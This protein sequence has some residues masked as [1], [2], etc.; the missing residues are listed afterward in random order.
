VIPPRRF[1]LPS[2]KVW[3]NV[4]LLVVLVLG[5]AFLPTVVDRGGSGAAS[6]EP[7]AAGPAYDQA[8]SAADAAGQAP[9][10][11]AQGDDGSAPPA[12]YWMVGRD[13]GIFSFGAAKFFGSTGNIRLNQPIV[14]M[15]A[16]RV[17]DGYWFVASDGGVFS[18][19]NASFYGSTGAIKLNKPI[20]G[21]A[22][23]PDGWGYWLVASDGGIFAFGDAQFY[24]STGAIKLNK[25]IVGM[26]STPDGKGYWLVASDGGM[27]SFG[28]ATFYGSTG[29][30]KLNK[31]I[32]AMGVTPDGAGYWLMATDGGLFSFGDATFYGSAAGQPG[33]GTFVGFVPN[34][35]G[36]GY[37]EVNS[38][39]K[40]M[41]FGDATDFGSAPAGVNNN[42]GAID[43]PT[44]AGLPPVDTTS[45]DATGNTLPQTSGPSGT[46]T[47]GP[48]PLG[49]AKPNILMILLDD[50]R[51]DGTMDN[52]AVLPKTKQW[53]AQ[54][55]EVFDNGYATTSLCCPERAT[56]WSGRVLHNNHVFD[57]YSGDNLDRNWIATRYLQDA[58]YKTAL[59]G[60]FITDWQ[61]R[62]TP[63]HF[64]EYTAFQ[65]GYDNVPFWVSDSSATGHHTV[66]A[67]YSTDFIGQTAVQY[68]D[69][70][71]QDKS[72]PWFMQV[73]PHAPH[74]TNVGDA[75][76]SSPGC[77]QGSTPAEY[78][79][80]LHQV[81]EWPSR[82]DN[83][84]LPTP[85][86]T[87]NT[88]TPDPAVQQL[89]G[90]SSPAT[91]KAKA[92]EDP[93]MRN[94]GFPQSCGALTWE[95]QQRTLMAV[96]DMVDGI[97][98]ELQKTGELSNTLVLFTSDNGFSFGDRGVTSKG[99]PYREHVLVPTMA[100][101][102]GVI[103]PGSVNHNPIGGED[104][105][106]TYLDAAQ[107]TP[108]HIQYP[109]DGRSF[110]PG[111]PTRT[112]KLLE[113][114]P[115][116]I[117]TPVGYK[118]HRGI[119]TWASIR[120]STYQ[121]IEWYGSDN[122]TVAWRE[123]Y[124]LHSDPWELHN[125]LIDPTMPQPDLAALSAQ[126][127][128]AEHCYGTTGPTACP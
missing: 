3:R 75:S 36:A 44:G 34:W 35:D 33:A 70:F 122:V 79:A 30:I 110:L 116:G 100:R 81:Y 46:F 51:A 40:A 86:G 15:A 124:D 4:A 31:P 88:Y 115:V 67:P 47:P 90:V 23:T 68:I 73:A 91:Q 27:F 38:A 98:T 39:G 50:A 93:Y 71:A 102:D 128:Q 103:A 32:T 24:G 60:K 10:D 5:V 7:G 19:G 54:G 76:Q 57:N 41:P 123:Y 108:P 114:G 61:F 84:P 74:I 29:A 94:N 97:M 62:Y 45:P 11:I 82:Y 78:D 125:I 18:F 104:F 127:H 16:N 48:L 65:G 49:K 53:L 107:Y 80:Y 37:W 52:P 112:T 121:Y 101:W 83:V 126:L 21:M 118:G 111:R 119:P 87:M 89:G 43:M 85:D 77:A 96:D 1:N 2:P 120:T 106:P 63:P 9:D 92:G 69:G 20:V 95:G 17:G 99:L 55:G 66:T 64:D 13:G 6:A 14:G 22:A 113:F 105:L 8:L 56:L 109:F 58:G 42:V 12:G 26:A 72:Q 117:P 28:D 25:P 59:D